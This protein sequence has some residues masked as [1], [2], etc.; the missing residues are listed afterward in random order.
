MKFSMQQ[1]FR[2]TKRGGGKKKKKIKK[3]KTKKIKKNQKTRKNTKAKKTKK[4]KFKSNDEVVIVENKG[5]KNTTG[6]MGYNIREVDFSKIESKG[7]L[8]TSNVIEYHYQNLDNIIEF[9]S[10]LD[11]RKEFDNVNFFKNI[12]DS[13]I[14][15][16]INNSSTESIYSS[17]PKFISELKDSLSK[18]FTPIT[19]NTLLPIGNNQIENHANMILIDNKEK[20]IELF[21]P[22]GYKPDESTQSQAVTNYHKKVKILKSFFRNILPEYVFINSVDFVQNKGFQELYDSNSGFCVTWSAI[23]VHYRILNPGVPT[24]IIV[25]FLDKY[26]NTSLILRYAHTIEDVLKNKK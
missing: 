2:K 16:D 22:H 23:F 4:V 5:K 7:T 11:K 18:Q 14:Q 21:E 19:V 3:K 25:K 13:M 15:V 20:Q 10:I 24:N 8:A 17:T 6:Y 1:L 26:I 9:L 12:Q